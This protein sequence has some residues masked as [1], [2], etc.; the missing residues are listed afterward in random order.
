MSLLD[1]VPT[2]YRIAA[3]AGAGALLLALGAGLTWWGLSP[4]STCRPSERT[5]PNGAGQTPRQWSSC[6]PACSP[7]SNARS[8][9]SPTSTARSSN[10]ASRSAAI[11][12]PRLG[13][14]R[15]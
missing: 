10:S 2:Q 11:N 9:G 14:F 13:H 3:L 12:P 5:R 7:S 6:K 15:S 8:A 4:A 1:V